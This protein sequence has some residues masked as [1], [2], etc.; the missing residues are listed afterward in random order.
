MGLR[1]RGR[2]TRR[3]GRVGREPDARNQP[4]TAYV[5]GKLPYRRSSE[6]IVVVKLED[7]LLGVGQQ[8]FRHPVDLRPKDSRLCGCFARQMPY[9]VMANDRRRGPSSSVCRLGGSV[10]LPACRGSSCVAAQA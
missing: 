10:A 4:T 5:V 3:D 7:E 2:L 9:Q 8:M 6:R 1:R